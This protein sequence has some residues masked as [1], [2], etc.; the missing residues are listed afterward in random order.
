MREYICF[1][2]KYNSTGLD[3]INKIILTEVEN[4][5]K[6]CG[7]CYL[8]NAQFG[9]LLCMS[10]KCIDNRLRFLKLNGFIITNSKFIG[11]RKT[12]SIELNISTEPGFTLNISTEGGNTMKKCPRISIPDKQDPSG[13]SDPNSETTKRVSVRNSASQ[14]EHPEVFSS[15]TTLVGSEEK[16]KESSTSISYKHP[17]PSPYDT[18]INILEK[19]LN[20]IFDEL[21]QW[22]YQLKK[23]GRRKF[24]DK[25][26]SIHRGDEWY[27]DM[28]VAFDKKIIA[29]IKIKK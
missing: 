8:T 25:T 18:D 14:N 26:A 16:T 5:I 6:N 2:T 17:Q 9:E 19:T 22:K 28:I 21:P 20:I 29:Q 11:K 13:P 23:M 10:S 7:Q 15:P 24:L 3:I 27:T 12:R 4:V 1:N